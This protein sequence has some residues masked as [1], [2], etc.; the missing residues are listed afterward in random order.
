MKIFFDHLYFSVV[1]VLFGGLGLYL[2]LYI[3]DSAL[4]N[5]GMGFG[6]KEVS[7]G[8]NITTFAIF[9]I[10]F[11]FILA[12]ILTFKTHKD[13]EEGDIDFTGRRKM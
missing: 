9:W 7:F 11:S 4:T 1:A 10:V 5:V 13:A 2:I 12:G 6:L 3:L 8:D